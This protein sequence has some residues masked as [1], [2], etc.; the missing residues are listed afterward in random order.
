MMRKFQLR[1]HLI[2]E[3]LDNSDPLVTQIEVTIHKEKT[4]LAA[5]LAKNRIRSDALTLDEL[6][7]EDIREVDQH[8]AELPLYCWINNLKISNEECV[9]SLIENEDLKLVEFKRVMDKKCF[10]IDPHCPNVLMFH[11]SL[12]EKIL[13][14][15]LVKTFKL[16]VQ[17]K[18]SCLAPHTVSKLLSKKDDLIV[19]HVSGGLVAAFI[20]SMTADLDSK[21]YV[22][23]ATNEDRYNELMNKIQQ[24]GCSKSELFFISI[25][26]FFF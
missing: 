20:A 17:D 10:M 19:T 11:Y 13:T 26:K 1:D 23:G 16:I 2:E 7:P 22:Y 15:E 18:S 3:P 24:I 21:I 14:H 8:K 9:Q 4:D 25:N 6:L 12:R 5:E